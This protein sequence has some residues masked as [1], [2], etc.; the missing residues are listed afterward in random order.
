MLNA[1]GVQ[2]VR[3]VLWGCNSVGLRFGSK[4]TKL[5]GYKLSFVPC[6]CCS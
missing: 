2:G 4:V 6:L 1:F 5:A 3:I